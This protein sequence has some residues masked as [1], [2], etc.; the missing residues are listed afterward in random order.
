LLYGRADYIDV[1]RRT[2]VDYKSGFIHGPTDAADATEAEAR[3]LRFY[4]YLASENGVPIDKGAIVRGTGGRFEIPITQES[5]AAEANAARA[6][7]SR[8]N[9]RVV[10][11]A[12]FD[13]LASPSMSAC[14]HC[15]C[16]P[17]CDRFWGEVDASWSSVCGVHI[18]G[19]V[20]GVVSL[21]TMGHRLVQIRLTRTRGSTERSDTAVEQVPASWLEINGGVLPVEGD[22]LRVTDARAVPQRPGVARA[23]KRGTA[24][25]RP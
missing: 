21:N 8:Y 19:Q 20:A 11:G 14:A 23:D 24:V 4:G 2:V 6:V 3:Q 1:G 22:T 9:Q 10:E 16:I 5:A 17:F 7:L 25:W 15:D 12:S 13:S 18:E